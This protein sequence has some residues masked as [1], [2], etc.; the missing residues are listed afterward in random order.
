MIM[1]ASE[2]SYFLKYEYQWLRF[3]VLRSTFFYQN[4]CTLAGRHG[5]DPF[6]SFSFLCVCVALV[7]C[8]CSEHVF[9]E[10]SLS[11]R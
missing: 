5:D 6:F 1:N 7:Q 4:L 10:I 2:F 9:C 3:Y 8:T 11:R